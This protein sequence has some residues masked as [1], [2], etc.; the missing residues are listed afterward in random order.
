MSKA[1]QEQLV[2]NNRKQH[3]SL[4][5]FVVFTRFARRRQLRE[6]RAGCVERSSG[7]QPGC[8]QGVEMTRPCLFWKGRTIPANPSTQTNR[9]NP[10]WVTR[11][12]AW[13][14][15]LSPSCGL[16]VLRP[17]LEGSAAPA[18]NQKCQKDR[19]RGR[20]ETHRAVLPWNGPVR[21][22]HASS[23]TFS[24]H[25]DSTPDGA[26]E[27]MDRPRPTPPASETATVSG[28][29]TPQEGKLTPKRQGPPLNQAVDRLRSSP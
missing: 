28:P 1:H 24:G 29:S 7:L 19:T 16:S 21:S 22:I 12:Q 2:P 14:A 25:V 23:N 10:A 27:N 9:T 20:S 11:V 5:G 3:P 13:R 15:T 8:R 17:V 4:C 18:H 26:S 6:A